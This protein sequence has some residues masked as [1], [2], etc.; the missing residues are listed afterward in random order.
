[1]QP[2]LA[3][4]KQLMAVAGV[5]VQY[6]VQDWPAEIKGNTIIPAQVP[7]RAK[8]PLKVIVVAWQYGRS[9]EPELQPAEPVT[10]TFYLAK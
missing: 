4:N 2:I 5:P 3:N 8:L 10:Q 7:L 1:M 6:C 9:V